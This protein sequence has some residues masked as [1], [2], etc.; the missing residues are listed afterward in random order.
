MGVHGMQRPFL[1]PGKQTT[2]Y[3][4]LK[5]FPRRMSPKEALQ[6]VPCCPERQLP[7]FCQSPEGLYTQGAA[8]KSGSQQAW[9]LVK[10]VFGLGH[11]LGG[12]VSFQ[13]YE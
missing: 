9:Y 12:T 11:E 10:E 6:L 1:F 3:M 13:L 4:H 5:M 7:S 8:V 2:I